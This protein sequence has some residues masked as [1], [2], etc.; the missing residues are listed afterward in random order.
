MKNCEDY[1]ILMNMVIDGEAGDDEQNE[2]LNHIESCESCK[3]RFQQYLSAAEE[4]RALSEEINPPEE[5]HSVIMN[6]VRQPART[7]RR[8]PVIYRYIGPIAACAA[9]LTLAVAAISWPQLGRVGGGAPPG[10]TIAA[11]YDIA[12]TWQ[13]YETEDSPEMGIGQFEEEGTTGISQNDGDAT[14]KSNMSMAQLKPNTESLIDNISGL[15]ISDKLYEIKDIGSLNGYAAYY[16]A[17]GEGELPA[18]ALELAANVQIEANNCLV[19]ENNS[20][21]VAEVLSGLSAAGYL[22]QRNISNLP[23]ESADSTECVILICQP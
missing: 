2:L 21:T 14:L 22:I 12:A 8:R 10:T 11:S 18:Y 6:A 9:M 13:Q 23:E 15:N 20:E 4:M 7:V 5:L 3:I 1:I 16:V 19:L 17:V